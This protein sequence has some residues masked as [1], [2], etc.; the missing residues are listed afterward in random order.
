MKIFAPFRLRH[1]L[2]ALLL[3]PFALV[4][5]ENTGNKPG[6]AAPDSAMAGHSDP[7]NAGKAGK[8]P[9][10][11]LTLILK[12]AS[13]T[14][15]PAAGGFITLGDKTLTLTAAD[16]AAL[17]HENISVLNGHT[18]ASETYGGVPISAILARLG[19]PFERKNEH[20]LLKTILI[21]EGTDGYRVIVST[22]ETLGAIRDTDAIVADALITPEGSKPLAADGAFKLVLPGDK[23]PQRWVQNLKSITFKTLE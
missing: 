17:P 4:A 1:G 16:V 13:Q 14:P 21:A 3:L 19:L 9:S 7:M 8:T 18:K 12:P 6:T 2:V 23:R 15:L 5:Q 10:T 22:Y 20:T 11:T